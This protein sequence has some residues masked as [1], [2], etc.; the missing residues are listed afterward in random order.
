VPPVIILFS[1]IRREKKKRGKYHL[2][3]NVLGPAGNVAEKKRERKTMKF[4]CCSQIGEKGKGG[5]NNIPSTNSL[6]TI[7]IRPS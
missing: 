4:P 5:E 2:V 7:F 3:Y 6:H 1:S